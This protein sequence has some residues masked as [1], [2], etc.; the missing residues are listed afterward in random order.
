MIMVSTC[1]LIYLGLN[2]FIFLTYL[3]NYLILLGE[4]YI[5]VMVSTYELIYLGLNVFIFLMGCF[6]IDFILQVEK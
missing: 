1:E 3:H 2:V 4:N 5:I 6:D